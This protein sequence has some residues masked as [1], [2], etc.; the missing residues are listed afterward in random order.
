MA[1]RTTKGAGRKPSK[2]AKPRKPVVAGLDPVKTETAKSSPKDVKVQG[3]VFIYALHDTVTNEVCYIGKAKNPDLRLKQHMR[4]SLRRHTPVCLWLRACRTANI[5]PRVTVL[6]ACEPA[7]WDREER[8]H[9]AHGRRLGWPLLN[10]ADG[11]AE[12]HCSTEQR[13][14]NAR[15]AIAKR[16]RVIMRLYRH[17]ESDLRFFKR[18]LPEAADQCAANLSRF[19]AAVE[20]HRNEGRLQELEQRLSQLDFIQRM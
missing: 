10:I 6:A 13:S 11:G 2:K 19:K 14:A 15:T 18:H 7:D 12:P 16:P 17:M 4:D 3:K 9:I 1:P 8:K 5:R 20:R